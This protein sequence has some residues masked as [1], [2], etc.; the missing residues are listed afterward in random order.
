MSSI[1]TLVHNI[2]VLAGT[3]TFALPAWEGVT[4]GSP[5]Y[6]LLFL[7]LGCLSFVIHCEDT[8]ICAPLKPAIQ[9]RLEEVSS[10][11]QVFVFGVMMSVVMEVR[12]EGVAR[13]VAGV[14]AL[15]SWL[16]QSPASTPFYPLLV[17]FAL[18][19]CVLLLDIYRFKHRFN[20]KYYMRMGT[21][22]GMAAL[23]ALLFTGVSKL[24]LWDGLWHVYTAVTTYLLLLAQRVKQQQAL[25]A[26]ARGGEGWGAAGPVSRHPP[27]AVTTQCDG[28][29]EGPPR[30]QCKHCWFVAFFLFST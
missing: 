10:A 29:G 1:S 15:V 23:G 24:W 14:W 27:P 12:A 28:G 9:Q 21:I 20:T 5:F 7:T 13:V 11:C 26:K 18:C 8:G 6:T 4:R 17:S 22:A 30:R 2:F 19:L 25:L 3:A 16:Q